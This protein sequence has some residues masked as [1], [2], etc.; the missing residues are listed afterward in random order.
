M[1]EMTH[2]FS[3]YCF[4]FSTTPSKVKH[5]AEGDSNDFERISDVSADHISFIP[6]FPQSKTPKSNV[7]NSSVDLVSPPKL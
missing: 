1:I 6:N 4:D 5:L 3:H 2:N 7:M